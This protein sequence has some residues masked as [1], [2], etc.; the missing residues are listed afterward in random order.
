VTADESLGACR[1]D[2]CITCGD[3]GIAMRVV[4]VDAARG[5]AVCLDPGGVRTEVDVAL[6]DPVAPG[7]ELLAHAGV[8]L[9]LLGNEA[10]A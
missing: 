8:A 5:A 10:L 9:A 2:H 6:V 4:E 7:D 1:D 3:E